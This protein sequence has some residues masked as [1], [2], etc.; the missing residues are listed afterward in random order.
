[1]KKV[2]LGC[3]VLIGLSLRGQII[4]SKNLAT[5]KSSKLIV[6]EYSNDGLTQDLKSAESEFWKFSK[7]EGSMP[8][9]DAIE[10][11]K[12]DKSTLVLKIGTKRAQSLTWRLELP[13]YNYRKDLGD[14]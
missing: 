7:V 1:M 9:S 4:S 8:L 3:L 12:S 5:I 2:L 13:L 6:A 10:K 11:A 14:L